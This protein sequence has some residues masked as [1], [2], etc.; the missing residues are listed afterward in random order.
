[1]SNNLKYILWGGGLATLLLLAGSAVIGPKLITSLVVGFGGEGDSRYSTEGYDT[2]LEFAPNM[3][4]S[5]AYKPY[6]QWKPASVFNNGRNMQAAPKG[7]IPRS[8]WYVAEDYKPYHISN[9][10]EAYN[11]STAGVKSPIMEMLASLEGDKK[12]AAEKQIEAKGKKIYEVFCMVCH[13]EQGDGQGTIVKNEKYPTPGTYASKVAVTEGQ[14]FHSITYG[15]NL[16]GSYASQITPQ[17][18]WAVIYYIKKTFMGG[19]TAAPATEKTT[20]VKATPAPAAN[21]K[22]AAPAKADATPPAKKTK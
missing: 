22:V 13:G 16:M 6:T 17:E 20:D 9:T 8:G 14:M 12:A 5:E 18:R 11:D 10:P 1:M 3:F 4:Y 7:T 21:A 2:G 19:V 15:K